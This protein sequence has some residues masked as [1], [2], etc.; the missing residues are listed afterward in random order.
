MNDNTMRLNRSR[1]TADSRQSRAGSAD[2]SG[3]QD[4][5]LAVGIP[6]REITRQPDTL[7]LGE[8]WEWEIPDSSAGSEKKDQTED[9]R[10]ASDRQ[11]AARE[12]AQ[13]RAH[14]AKMMR[15]LAEVRLQR[16]LEENAR[17]ASES[18]CAAEKAKLRVRLA[19]KATAAY[20][21]SS[22][23]APMPS[24]LAEPGALVAEQLSTGA[25]QDAG[26]EAPAD[27][28]A[29]GAV[30]E[31]GSTGTSSDSADDAR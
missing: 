16:R 7:E 31:T 29:V 3:L 5:M 9:E 30:A 11:A 23:Y 27:T 22:A 20:A 2:K 28:P 10:L 12:N 6:P 19:D 4:S 13:R 21:Q 26:T 25:G 14:S 24:S 17:I 15:R 18:E 8:Q 1:R